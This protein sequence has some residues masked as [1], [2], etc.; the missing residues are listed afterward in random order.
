MPP[1]VD[2]N[3]LGASS[4]SDDPWSGFNFP[5]MTPLPPNDP[6]DPR[7]Q[8]WL[9]QQRPYQPNV[10][11]FPFDRFPESNNAVAP[12]L[13][14]QANF[15]P[16]VFDPR[17]QLSNPMGGAQYPADD[18]NS[19]FG[20]WQSADSFADRF[21]PVYGPFAVPG[22]ETQGTPHQFDQ[23]PVH[24]FDQRF[25]EVYNQ[26][27]HQ[28]QEVS[29]PDPF[30]GTHGLT[31][32]QQVNHRFPTP[33]QID[34]Y[35]SGPPQDNFASRFNA[36]YEQPLQQASDPFADRFNSVFEQH[37]QFMPADP[38]EAAR[39]HDEA[40]NPWIPTGIDQSRA[41]VEAPEPQS[42]VR[43]QSPQT[44]LFANHDPTPSVFDNTP[45]LASSGMTSDP[46]RF[47]LHTSGATPDWARIAPGPAPL[48]HGPTPQPYGGVG[49]L[50]FATGGGFMSNWV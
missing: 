13:E 28:A 43:S 19:R 21:A 11:G 16:Q 45:W 40:G 1:I 6:R 2:L 31:P 38:F 26:P 23:F 41:Q 15:I 47:G 12:G 34:T 49:P 42:F 22:S 36:V 20:Q 27:Y 46:S 7:D 17:N 30:I 4:G 33:W 48:F 50:G 39:R 8:F 10:H 3:R 14:H 44:A 18:F 5:S 32:Q 29:R 24:R 35:M 9:D 37:S 25:N